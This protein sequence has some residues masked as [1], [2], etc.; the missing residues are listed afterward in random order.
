[1][2]PPGLSTVSASS[3]PN[4]VA[5][6]VS[7][8]VDDPVERWLWPDEAEYLAHFPRFVEAFGGPAFDQQTVWK[9]GAFSAVA[10]WLAPG[11]EPD[12]E[13]L[14]QVL[15]ETVSHDKH[16]DTFAVLEQMGEGHPVAPHWYLP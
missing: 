8:F 4:V 14:V 12:G 15:N 3:S 9:L 11:A 1:M 6:I 5:T 7:A 13:A 2:T 16:E 10:L